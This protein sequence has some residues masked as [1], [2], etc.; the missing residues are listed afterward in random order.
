MPRAGT[1]ICGVKK[2]RWIGKAIYS[3]G[4]WAS[5]GYPGLAWTCKPISEFIPKCDLFVEPFAGLG[6]ISQLVNAKEKILNDKSKYANK[7][8]KKFGYI[9]E[10]LDFIDCIKKYDSKDTVFF[11]DPPWRSKIYEQNDKCFIDRKPIEY[12]QKFFEL[13]PQLK[14]QLWFICSDTHEKEIQKLLSK[15]G[16]PNKIIYARGNKKIMGKRANVRICSNK[17]FVNYHQGEIFDQY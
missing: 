13:V 11:L 17:P 4:G 6:R 5:V 14:C 8:N 15:S 3:N 9:V 16:F 12:Y 2:I 7:H 10:D 1:Y